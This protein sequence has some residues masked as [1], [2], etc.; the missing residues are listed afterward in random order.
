MAIGGSLTALATTAPVLA[1]AEAA[2]KTSVLTVENM[3][4][5]LCPLTVKTAMERV[6]GVTS[7]VVDFDAKTATVTFDPAAVTIDAIAAASAN[8]GYPAYAAGA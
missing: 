5:E 3:T 7:V 8:V 1:Q 6:P 4:C 2:T